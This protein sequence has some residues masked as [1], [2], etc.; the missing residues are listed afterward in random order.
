[1]YLPMKKLFILLAI[2][3]PMMACLTACS[4][5]DDGYNYP[6]VKL[7][8]L[9]AQTDI[10]GRLTRIISD[11]GKY[12]DVSEDVSEQFYQPDTLIR[13]IANYQ[14]VAGEPQQSGFYAK[15]YAWRNILAPQPLAASKFKEG[16][17]HDPVEVVSV[18]KGYDYINLMLNV[19]EQSGKHIFHFVEE[20]V[21]T[22]SDGLNI[23]VSLY[24]KAAES[25][26]DYDKRVYLSLPYYHY[27][28]QA[29]EEGYEGDVNIHLSIETYD[30]GVLNYSFPVR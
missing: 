12:M 28:T 25:T 30:K 11:D 16:V 1:M 5:D 17:S 2:L 20:E 14:Q 3:L 21:R 29:V 24:H 10:D 7:E 6:S 13:I 27:L 15:L 19:R 23:Y 26:Q 22:N 4:N 8:F 9:S 18:W